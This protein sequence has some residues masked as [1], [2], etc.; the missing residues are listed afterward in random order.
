LPSLIGAARFVAGIDPSPVAVIRARSKFASVIAAGRA[1]FRIGVAER[2]PFDSEFQS[3]CT[4]NT[5]YFWN[6]LDAGFTEI[7]RVLQPGGRLVVG[8]LPKEW[9]DR[10]KLPRDIFTPRT[11]EAVMAAIK[12][13]GFTKVT[14]DRP[15]PSTAWAAAVATR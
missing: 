15:W 9:M 11:P 2:L 3:V 5:I 8:F 7:H 13:V 4:V 6:S 12:A 10:M 1:D 14:L